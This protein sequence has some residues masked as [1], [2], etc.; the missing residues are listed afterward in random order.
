MSRYSMF[1]PKFSSFLFRKRETKKLLKF[2]KLNKADIN[3]MYNRLKKQ[4]VKFY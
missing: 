3:L 2:D 4:K 1:S